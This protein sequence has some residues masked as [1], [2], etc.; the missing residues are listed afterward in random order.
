M[1]DK[2]NPHRKKRFSNR[3]EE[4]R[5]VKGSCGWEDQKYFPPSGDTRIK[6]FTTNLLS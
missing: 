4:R 6:S 2:G 1:S 3:Y 5:K